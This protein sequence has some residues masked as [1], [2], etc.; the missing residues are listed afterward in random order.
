M[1]LW[2]P[3]F[4]ML[5]KEKP[6]TLEDSLSDLKALLDSTTQVII[7]E[8]DLDRNIRKFNKGAENLLG[9]KAE[10]VI[11]KQKSEIFHLKD[12]IEH[13]RSKLQTKYGESVNTNETFSFKLKK[14]HLES[15]E[16][17]YVKKDGSKFPVQ[18]VILQKLFQMVI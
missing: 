4:N 1:I 12:E 10:E 8:T 16:W 7:I 3:V 17:T 11:G 2:A 5:L 13:Y 18:L 6:I 14:N 15:N 9:Y